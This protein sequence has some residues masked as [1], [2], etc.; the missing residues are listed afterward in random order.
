M[1]KPVNTYLTFDCLTVIYR[2]VCHITSYFQPYKGKNHFTLTQATPSWLFSFSP[3]SRRFCSKLTTV[4]I[5]TSPFLSAQHEE[6]E[7]RRRRR[8]YV[9]IHNVRLS[10]CMHNTMPGRGGK[11]RRDEIGAR[12]W[13]ADSAAPLPLVGMRL[14]APP[15]RLGWK[16]KDA[17]R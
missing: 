3:H 16:E 11:R 13:A 1:V 7:R 4:Q 12:F 15:P 9:T 2:K 10:M 5:L 8:T 17:A 6:K 14:E